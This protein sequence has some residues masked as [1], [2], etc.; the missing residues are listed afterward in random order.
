MTV[1]CHFKETSD[2]LWPKMDEEESLAIYFSF[3]RQEW[4]S[5]ANL[6]NL[7]INWCTEFGM[8]A[9]GTHQTVQDVCYA[10]SIGSL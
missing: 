1:T 8:F 10:C 2:V 6:L 4:A 5:S 3:I 7:A 9:L